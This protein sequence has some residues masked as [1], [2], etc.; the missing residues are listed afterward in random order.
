MHVYEIPQ[1]IVKYGQ[2]RLLGREQRL[3]F[4]ALNLW[5]ESERASMSATWTVCIMT[6]YASKD[7]MGVVITLKSKM[8][9]RSGSSG[10]GYSK[11]T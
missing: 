1:I 6:L 5:N 11:S 2:R 3:F 4:F 10:G 9:A 8:A 7:S